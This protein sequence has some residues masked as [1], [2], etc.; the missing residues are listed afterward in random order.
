MNPSNHQNYGQ[1][2]YLDISI[3][4]T[5]ERNYKNSLLNEPARNFE[6]VG[7]KGYKRPDDRIQ[8]EICDL[9]M[10]DKD[11]DASDIEVKVRNGTVLLSGTVSSR[12]DK[13]AAEMAIEN[14]MGVEDIQNNI[15][16]R[17][18]SQ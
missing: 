2:E 12:M 8:E 9:L 17:Q 14:I 6:G 18:W 1:D 5:V 16:L 4:D 10:K 7:P 15:K 13:L 3:S 11:I